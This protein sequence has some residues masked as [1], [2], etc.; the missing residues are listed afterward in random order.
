MN[1]DQG[2]KFSDSHGVILNSAAIQRLRRLLQHR[3]LTV[4]PCLAAARPAGSLWMRQP[5][6]TMSASGPALR[7]SAACF[8]GLL[9]RMSPMTGP[10]A[11]QPQSPYRN[12]R[13][14]SRNLWV[15]RNV[16]D[17]SRQKRVDAQTEYRGP[18]G[19]A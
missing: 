17:D 16:K 3:A 14:E 19:V 9:R 12:C 4:T 15:I 5:R 7:T 1:P 13:L 10:R 18:S 8:S 2:L 6:A 11:P